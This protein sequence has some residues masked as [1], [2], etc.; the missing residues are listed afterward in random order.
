MTATVPSASERSAETTLHSF[1]SQPRVVQ[2]RKKY[3]DIKSVEEPEGPT[4]YGNIMFDKR[5][6]RGNTYAL[7]SLPATSQPDPLEI[8]RMRENARRALARQRA[9]KQLRTSPEAV[10][11]R[12]HVY[13]QTELYLEEITERI[14]EA[15]YGSQTDAFLDRPSTP[16]FVP[17]KTGDDA[18]TQV[19]IGDLFNFNLE[20]KPILEVIVAKTVEQSLIEVLE[21]EELANL[22]KQQ[23]ASEE[24]IN[25]EVAEQQRLEEQVRR[26]QEEKV[27]RKEQQTKVLLLEKETAEKIAARIFALTYMADLVPTVFG[28][29]SNN[30]YFYDPVERDLEQDFL[31]WLMEQVDEQLEMN[32]R[33]RLVLDGMIREVMLR[34]LKKYENR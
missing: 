14:E 17:V 12:Q 25:T 2:A 18:T 27:R 3:R 9:R 1:S 30:G 29:L 16:L 24:I 11:N 7:Q 8:Q 31:P 22:R 33:G 32:N 6:V 20:V 28:A 34:R 19:L 5:V 21:E 23:S 15:D 10:E 13:V 4:F 26:H